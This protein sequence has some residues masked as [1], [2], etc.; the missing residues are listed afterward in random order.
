[1]SLLHML[2]HMLARKWP[3]ERSEKRNKDRKFS[4]GATCKTQTNKN[5]QENVKCHTVF[6]AVFQKNKFQNAKLV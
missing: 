2:K 1:M 3:D 5:P 4:V 6:C